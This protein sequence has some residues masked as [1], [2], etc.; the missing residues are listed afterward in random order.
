MDGDICRGKESNMKRFINWLFHPPVSAPK[1]TVLIRWMAGGVFLW[2]GILKFVYKNQGVGRFTK[3]G[4]PAPHLMAP[5]VAVLEIV[6]GLLLMAGLLTRFISIPFVVEMLVAMASTKIA[7][8]L[9]KSPL[10]LPPS[11]PTVGIWAVLHEVRSEYAQ[12]MS[13]LYLGIV[14]PGVWSLD[15]ALAR[16]ARANAEN[17]AG[18]SN[19]TFHADD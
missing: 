16:R 18:L 17:V 7:L 13:V 11:P 14:G 19:R 2:E 3:I 5:F 4:I 8:C 10:P 15:A 1:A 9:G 6:G 12:L